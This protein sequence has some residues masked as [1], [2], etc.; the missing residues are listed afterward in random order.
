MKFLD[1][2]EY[3]VCVYCTMFHFPALPSDGPDGVQQL[4]EESDLSCP[5]CG[6]L[7]VAASLGGTRVQHCLQCRGV[8][9]TNDA[10]SQIIKK[11][12]AEYPGEPAAPIP[13]DPSELNRKVRCPA[14]SRAMDAHPYYGP[15]NVVVD[16]CGSC[17]LIWLDHGEIA[18]IE[19]APGRR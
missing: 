16:T 17:Y 18:A 9:A 3:F 8:L 1:G 12:R 15:G 6:V 2:R 14:C 19:R 13:L 10:F 4:A 11:R 5:V 7:L